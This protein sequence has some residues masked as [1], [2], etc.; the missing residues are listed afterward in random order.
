[1][2]DQT[3]TV[4]AGPPQQ[5][6]S[7]LN[8]GYTIRNQSTTTAVWVSSQAGVTPGYGQKIG[9][10]GSLLW[11]G[12]PCYAALDTTTGSATLSMSTS[13]QQITDPVAIAQAV[14]AQGIPNVLTGSVLTPSSSSSTAFVFSVSQYASIAATIFY[15]GYGQLVIQHL[16]NNV[17]VYARRFTID[18]TAKNSIQFTTP[19]YGDTIQLIVSG[20]T[21]AWTSSTVY[22]SNR[23]TPE[24]C[25]NDTLSVVGSGNQ[26]FTANT[27]YKLEAVTTVGGLASFNYRA[28]PPVITNGSVWG[29]TFFDP[30]TNSIGFQQIANSKQFAID[31][32]GT[33]YSWYGNFVLPAGIISFAFQSDTTQTAIIVMS[34]MLPT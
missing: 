16:A 24:K 34:G 10:L 21:L 12:G 20:G 11:N 4:N 32:S 1:M 30:T 3:I 14:N 9:A 8:S 15:T 28:T 6:G 7:N 18:S 22:G 23:Q 19:V 5:I 2:T 13:T 17:P 29:F 33:N 31:D 25:I 26:S 27:T